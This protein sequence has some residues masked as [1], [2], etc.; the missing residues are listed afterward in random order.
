MK[1]KRNA[2][3]QCLR[4]IQPTLGPGITEIVH[5]C[6]GCQSRQLTIDLS[7]RVGDELDSIAARHSVRSQAKLGHHSHV[8]FKEA[9]G[10]VYYGTGEV[11]AIFPEKCNQG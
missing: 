1:W 11:K 3:V 6:F 9:T 2:A 10:V 8:P 5:C 7:D 4:R